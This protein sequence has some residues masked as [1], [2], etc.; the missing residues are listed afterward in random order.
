M[1]GMVGLWSASSLIESIQRGTIT[2]DTSVVSSAT[3]T[4]TSVDMSRSRLRFNGLYVSSGGNNNKMAAR[5]AFTNA[6]TIT[7]TV[8]GGAGTGM[9]CVVSYEVIQYMPG[10]VRNIQRGTALG[11]SVLTITEV[12]MGKSEVDYLGDQGSDTNVNITTTARVLLSTTTA[13]NNASVGITNDTV[14]MQVTE[15]F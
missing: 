10:V 7:V 4:I 12:Q 1:G 2:Y 13:I 6:T 5:I 3:A 8:T 14:G 11:N 15:F 9:S